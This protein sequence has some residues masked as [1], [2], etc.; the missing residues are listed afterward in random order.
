MLEPSDLP[1]L[2]FRALEVVVARQHEVPMNAVNGNELRQKRCRKLHRCSVVA[3]H[4]DLPDR[5]TVIAQIALSRNA[6]MEF[7]ALHV[8]G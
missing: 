8:A 2:K 7:K 6:E 4:N 5:S 1:P 3:L